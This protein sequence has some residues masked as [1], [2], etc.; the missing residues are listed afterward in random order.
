MKMDLKDILRKSNQGLTERQG[1]VKILAALR[2]PDPDE[3][4]LNRLRGLGL[5]IDRVVK[6]K[7][8]G[9]IDA[10]KLAALRADADVE[11]AELSVPLKRHS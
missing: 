2:T 3:A 4:C 5:T 6:N 8:I 9:S 11:E 10:E 1:Q 7:I